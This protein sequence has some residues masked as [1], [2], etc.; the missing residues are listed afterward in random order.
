MKL[1]VCLLPG[2]TF[3]SNLRS[4]PF[5]PAQGLGH[6][7]DTLS[8]L[9]KPLS[10]ADIVRTTGKLMKRNASAS[11]KSRDVFGIEDFTAT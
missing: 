10:T 9:P 11:A 5:A 7:N 3:L 6:Q 4:A 1:V 8:S 2:A